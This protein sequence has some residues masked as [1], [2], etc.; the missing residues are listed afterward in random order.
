MTTQTVTGIIVTS[1]GTI[2]IEATATDG[3]ETSMT[4]DTTYT[5]TAQQIGTYGAGQTVQ[6]AYIQ[7]ATGIAYAYILRNG[8]VM[9]VIQSLGSL[10]YGSSNGAQPVKPIQLIP[11]DVLRVLTFA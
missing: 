3:T 11:G 9:S 5:V 2:P 8:K 1:T 7:S 10:A 4:T 6:K